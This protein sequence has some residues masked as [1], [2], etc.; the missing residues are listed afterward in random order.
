MAG[1]G[2]W[3]WLRWPTIRASFGGRAA[4]RLSVAE[5]ERVGNLIKQVSADIP[6]LLVEHDIDRVFSLADHVTVMN[7][8]CCWT[9][10]WTMP[11]IPMPC[12]R[13]I[14][15]RH[16]R[17]RGIGPSRRNGRP[18]LHACGRQRPLRQKPHPHDVGFDIRKARSWPLLGR[19]GAGKSTLLKSIIG[20]APVSAG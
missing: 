9:G 12:A 5:R 14:S 1:S 7:E 11:A 2:C 19:N 15:A 18:D 4:G 20:I 16:R 17:G 10:P 13:S 8:R 6:V 3:T